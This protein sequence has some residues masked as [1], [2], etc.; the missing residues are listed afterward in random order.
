M[1]YLDTRD[2]YKRKC[3]LEDYRDALN[4]ARDA[5]EAYENEEELEGL[6]EEL[7]KGIRFLT[8]QGMNIED[9]IRFQDCINSGMANKLS[10]SLNVN[11]LLVDGK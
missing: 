8:I 3:E 4:D 6:E 11:I 9:L 1:S 5:F 10:Y 7:N 2:L